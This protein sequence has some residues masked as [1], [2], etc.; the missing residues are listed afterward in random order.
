MHLSETLEWNHKS[1]TC[2]IVLEGTIWTVSK[3]QIPLNEAIK[4]DIVSPRPSFWW[5]GD[6]LHFI[7]HSTGSD[8]VTPYAKR[9]FSNVNKVSSTKQ[10]RSFSSH[11]HHLMFKIKA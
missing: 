8:T 3:Y 5:S 11:T 10:L 7:H 2:K 4:A 1:C 6:F 9:Q